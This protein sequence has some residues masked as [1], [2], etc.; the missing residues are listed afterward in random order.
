MPTTILSL[1][2]AG[3]G[4]GVGVGVGV[5]AGGAG[6]GVSGVQ[7]LLKD[8]ADFFYIVLLFKLPLVIHHS[9]SQITLLTA[10]L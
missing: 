6:V 1:T 3:G 5:G 7:A 8:N 9:N 4:V 10:V 2:G